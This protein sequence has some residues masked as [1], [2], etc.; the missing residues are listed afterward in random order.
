LPRT[1]RRLHAAAGILSNLA[2]SNGSG[3]PLMKKSL[4]ASCLV[5]LCSLGA[6]L[7]L[8]QAPPAGSQPDPQAHVAALAKEL[9]LSD[10]QQPQFRQI[11]DEERASLM[12]SMK[13]EREQNIAIQTA[14]QNHEQIEDAAMAKLKPILSDEQFR[15]YQD[16]V[17]AE[18]YARHH[19]AP[20]GSSAPAAAQ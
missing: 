5:A 7:A 15:K 4:A 20:A 6:A 10:A 17:A 18:A 3:V 11:L 16:I 12:A 1:P 19:R 9:N 14:H 13:T 2:F 8:A